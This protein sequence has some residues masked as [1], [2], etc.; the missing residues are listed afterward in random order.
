MD[1]LNRIKQQA[2]ALLPELIDIRR[3]LHRH[4][5]LSMHEARTS[6]FIQLRL[7]EMGVPFETGMAKHGVVGLIKGKNPGSRTIALRADMDALPITEQNETAYCSENPGVMHACGH[8]VHMTS[9]LG[10]SAI[11]NELKD[12]FEGTIKL[13]FQPSEEKFPGG[14]S[15]MIAEGVLENPRPEKMFGQHVL[16]TLEAGKVGFKA[17]KYMAS[18]DEVYLTVKGRGGHGATP[19]LNVD[20]V[21]IAAHILVALQQI[22]SRNAPPQL[23]AVLSFGR[24]IAEGQTNIIPNEVKLDGTLR[25]FDENWRAEAHMKITHMAQSIAESMGGSCD[26]FIDKGYPFLVNDAE[27]TEK[28]RLAAIEYLGAEQVVDLD[29][30]MTAEDFAYYS[31]QLPVCFYRLGVRNE[32]KGIVHNLHTTRFDVDESSLETGAGLMAWLAVKALENNN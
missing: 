12:E 1:L 5:E 25:T 24:F 11:L 28:A 32:E 29:L 16:P 2:A 27:V 22:V 3:H 17:G 20:P 21:L 13:I 19:E 14:A 7:I 26:V 23:P 8:D 10:A 30:R 6:N 9:L 15:M 18:T 4:P 31:Q